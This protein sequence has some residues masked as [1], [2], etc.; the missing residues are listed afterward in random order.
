MPARPMSVAPFS[1]G[2]ARGPISHVGIPVT[3]SPAL[4]A[5][6]LPLTPVR[7][8]VLVLIAAG[9]AFAPAAHPLCA[10]LLTVQSFYRAI[11]ALAIRRGFNPDLP[12]HLN[13]V[14]ET[15]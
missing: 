5:I 6:T 8:A 14:T 4:L 12:P 15:V 9:P 13:K 10:P 11:N 2:P 1:M 3:D 7:P